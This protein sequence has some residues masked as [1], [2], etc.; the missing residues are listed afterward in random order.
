MEADI[1][2]GD[3]MDAHHQ[4]LGSDT[5]VMVAKLADTFAL[6]AGDAKSHL[7]SSIS[8]VAVDKLILRI[9][10]MSSSQRLLQKLLYSKV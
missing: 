2:H 8:P 3:S 4:R 7:V 9:P 1:Q 10:L 6:L 5:E